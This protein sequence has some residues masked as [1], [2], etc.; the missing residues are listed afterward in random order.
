MAATS[1]T[2]F[3]VCILTPCSNSHPFDERRILVTRTEEDA[4]KIGRSVVRLQPSSNNA[5]FD[6]KV[7]SR[8]HAVLWANGAGHFMI[9]DTRSSNG[10]FINNERL[11]ASGEENEPR[12]L[13]SGDIL[14]LGVEIIDTA[15]K[16]ASGCVTCIVRLLNERGEE[17]AGR[18]KADNG[19]FPTLLQQIPPNYTLV[20]NEQLFILDQY[21]KEAQHRENQLGLKLQTLEE[22]L[23]IA[24]E[25]LQAKW[26]EHVDQELLLSRIEQLESQL[27]R[28]ARLVAAKTT[29]T[30]SAAASSASKN[31]GGANDGNA[32]TAAAEQHQRLATELRELAED[33]GRIEQMAKESLRAMQEQVQET[34]MK[35]H[36]AEMSLINVEEECSFLRQ[37]CADFETQMGRQRED[38]D[39][40]LVKYNSKTAPP[41]SPPPPPFALDAQ[42]EEES[43]AE[44]QAEAVVVDE[45]EQQQQQQPVPE[46]LTTT[47][48]AASKQE[49]ATQMPG[50]DDEDDDEP[51]PPPPVPKKTASKE[52]ETQVPD[53][54]GD[55]PSPLLLPQVPSNTTTVKMEAATQMPPD[56]P[57]AAEEM[58]AVVVAI[59]S[60]IL[61]FLFEFVSALC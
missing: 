59:V 51:P 34:A 29:G 48:T 21:V 54:V 5:I 7:L 35:L 37:R 9:K 56:G 52:A 17:C 8:N 45:P 25:A 36:D 42:K 16:V 24:Q 20:K 10:T 2:G 27:D 28:R 43:S 53:G 26:Q 31:G 11:S 41:P 55:G 33:R 46:T 13:F 40:L 12:E 49:V 58:A 19:T 61:M 60:M 38:Y 50:E 6:C 30:T 3:P 1:A 14:Q 22:Q 32:A 39:A 57:P 15:K 18:P 23:R 4:V 47:T 44:N